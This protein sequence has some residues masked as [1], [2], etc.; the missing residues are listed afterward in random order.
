MA[1]RRFSSRTCRLDQS[2]LA[3]QLQ[4]A[5]SYRRIAG[6]FTSSLFEVAHEWL[7]SVAD[8][9]I[10]C[11]VDL[12]PEDLKIAQ[13]REARMLGRWN[14]R[15]IE[16]ESLLNRERYQLL[17]AFLAKRGQVIRVAPDSVCG[18]V[19]GKAGVIERSDG[20]KLGFMGSMNETRHG[21][22]RHYEILW[23]DDSPDGVAWIE[24]EFEYLWNAARPL[25]EAVCREVRRRGRRFEVPLPEIEAE[26]SL[27]PAA[28]I[29]SPLY[30]EGMALQPW[31]QGFVTECLRHYNDHGQVRLLLADE[32]GLGK[33]LSLGT[34]AL[35][36][37]LLSEKTA[38]RRKPVVIFAPATLCEQWQTE[39]IDKLGIPCARWHSSRKVWLDPDERAISPSGPEHVARCPLRIGIVSTGLMVQPS[40]EKELLTGLTFDLVILDEAHKAR[41]R[42]GYG[43]NA[44]EPNELLAFMLAIANRADH[45]LL[46]T[47]TPIQT[48]A[49]D[50]WDL[51]R[52]LHRGSSGFVLGNELATWHNPARVLPIL[53]GEQHVAELNYGWQLLRSPLPTMESTNEPNA[54][55][56]FRN[57]R[58][59]LGLPRKEHLAGAL[60]LLSTDLRDD[61]E[62]ELERVIDG[63]SFFQRENPFVR[64][65]VLRKRATLEDQGLLDKIAVNIHP[66]EGLVAD[67]HRFNALFQ[68]IAL[69]TTPDFDRAYEEARAF[70]RVLAKGGKGG[71]FMKNLME[72][73]VCSSVVAGINTAAV[74]LEGRQ[75]HEATEDVEADLAIQTDAERAAL[76]TLIAALQAMKADPKLQ[77]IRYYLRDEGWL[78]LGCIIFSQYY[79][80][81][82]WVA[83][84]LAAE[85]PGEIIGLYAGADRSRLYRD[86][87]AVGIAREALKRMVADHDIRLMVATDA[88]CEGLNLQTL[89]TLIN[90]DLPWNPTRL[91]QRIGRIKRFGQARSTVDMLNLVHQGTVDETVYERL[92]ERMRNRY[93]LFGGLPD[94]IKDDWI[95]DLETLGEKMD[96]YIEERRQATGFDLRYNDT[97]RSTA[98]AWRDCA[99]VLSR[100]D[101]DNLMRQGWGG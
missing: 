71:G 4:G 48:Q 99:A 69:R 58:E 94:T 66:E 64:H 73:R 34:A 49:E 85:L 12:A 43:Q 84:S 8:V 78:S 23:E 90:V 89:G 72:Q 38:R 47:A 7:E 1:I 25:P 37:C 40:K 9:R 28:L 76:E 11:N 41:S 87:Q 91:E 65:V 46:G 55:R 83:D 36:L 18:F 13:L 42:Q 68:G 16:A 10:V 82:R 33:T 50:L 80:T 98:D 67:R 62:T 51:I 2:F 35:T 93:D 70:G 95:D 44:G 32:V 5:R 63:A 15:S 31:Q 75:V 26:D 57:L 54:R 27:A 52:V 100:R 101:L 3:E 45:V 96:Q 86:G 74:L 81:A 30:R 77:A 39:M 59:D 19:H 21:W 60:P 14:E 56:L 24:A 61:L 22:Q 20:R 79:D 29:E 88:A 17:D 92:S 53:S 97:I 6:Y